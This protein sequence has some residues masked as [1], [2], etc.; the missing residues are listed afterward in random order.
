MATSKDE[1]IF[2]GIDD[3]VIELTGAD[4]EAYIADRKAM[5]EA[6]ALLSPDPAAKAAARKSALAK[7]AALGL[8]ADEIE[9]L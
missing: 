9:A 5:A 2:I 3:Q 8:T 4:K 7:L 1:Q 6:H